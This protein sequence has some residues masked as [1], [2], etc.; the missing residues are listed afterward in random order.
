MRHISNY[1]SLV[2]E[3]LKSSV[4]V[5]RASW[6]AQKNEPKFLI[7]FP[8]SLIIL[9]SWSCKEYSEDFA[10]PFS[11]MRTSTPLVRIGPGAGSCWRM[12]PV[13]QNP[14]NPFH[15]TKPSSLKTQINQKQRRITMYA[16]RSTTQRTIAPAARRFASAAA[17][18]KNKL[19]PV[20]V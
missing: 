8:F 20:S 1:F 2:T 19:V 10:V 7:Y 18:P 9:L 4:V 14:S 5:V 6:K 15:K 3:R 17:A 13:S 16:L 12:S 11:K